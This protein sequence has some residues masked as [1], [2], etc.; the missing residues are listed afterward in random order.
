M[1]GRERVL[2]ALRH[3]EPD[4]VPVDCGGTRSSGIMAIAY[5][6]LKRHLGVQGGATRV[7]DMVQQLALPEPW[8]L[9]RFQVDVIDLVQAYA[10]ESSQWREWSLPDGSP[11]LIP[12]WLRIEKR[13]GGWV[14][15]HEDG[16][17]I[18]RMPADSLYFDQA[19]WPLLGKHLDDF[20]DLP[21]HMDRVMWSYMRDPLDNSAR[22][23]DYH[24]RL[25]ES[26]RRLSRESDRAIQFSFGGN[27]FEWGQFLYRSDEFFVNLMNHRKEMEKMLD[28][29]TEIHLAAMDPILDAVAPHVDIFKVGDDLGMQT[30]PMLSP[31]LYHELFY[32]RHKK[33]YRRVKDRTDLFVL[34]HSCGAVAEFIPDLIDAGVDALNPVQIAA[35]GMEPEKLKREFGRD[36]VFWGGGVDAQHV[37]PSADPERV[38]REAR[39]NVDVF[40]PGGGYVFCATHNITAD[41]PP[42]NIVAMFDEVNGRAA[43]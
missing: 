10:E 30:G 23:P 34:L 6:R 21:D 36:I 17:I 35:A 16:E 26:A 8:F 7:Y 40:R 3:R 38:R 43:E 15:I 31:E 27:L 2:A 41:V 1:T 33:I 19:V 24:T 14:C 32:P 39:R 28:R 22:F 29:L 42:E 37:L 12:S 4:R 18:A 9:D 11:A 5:D 20:G 13:D 25:A